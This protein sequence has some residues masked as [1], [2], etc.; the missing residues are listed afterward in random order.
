MDK[1]FSWHHFE[2]MSKTLESLGYVVIVFGPLAGIGL[3]VFGSTMFKVS[4]ILLI[5]ASFL[6]SMYHVSFSLL[7]NG[8]RELKKMLD[9]DKTENNTGTLDNS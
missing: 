7:M 8:I 4:G 2:R 1:P 9:E 5:L 3:L 6:I